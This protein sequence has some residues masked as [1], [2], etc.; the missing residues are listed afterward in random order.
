MKAWIFCS[1]FKLA[2]ISRILLLDPDIANLNVNN[3]E[4]FPSGY[5]EEPAPIDPNYASATSFAQVSS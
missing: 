2:I 5:F 3:A 1:N 4:A